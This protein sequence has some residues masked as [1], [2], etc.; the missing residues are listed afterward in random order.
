MTAYGS[1]SE[2]GKI[3]CLKS[4]GGINN[5]IAAKEDSSVGI[6]WG[7]QGQAIG[8]TAQSETDGAANTKAIVGALGTKD[9]YAALLCK[10]YEI[11]AQGNKP[12][13]QGL[14][15]YKDWFLPSRKELDCLHDHQKEIGGFANDFYW[16]SS[17]FSGYPE[18]SAWDQYFGEGKHPSASEDDFNR[19]RCVRSF[20]K[21]SEN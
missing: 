18:Y 8:P 12:C 17:E 2:G 3:A 21:N 10:N 20:N 9:Q 6:S 4:D 7:G 13:K 5:L 15:C 14:T 16:T 11:D 19:V 1:N